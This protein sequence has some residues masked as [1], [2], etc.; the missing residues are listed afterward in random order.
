VAASAILLKEK[1]RRKPVSQVAVLLAESLTWRDDCAEGDN[2][3]ALVGIGSGAAG[4]LTPGD[5]QRSI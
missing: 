3:V 4:A 5:A 1:V 2:I